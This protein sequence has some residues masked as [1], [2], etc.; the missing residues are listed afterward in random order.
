[1]SK[2]NQAHQIYNRS[3][4]IKGERSSSFFT[5]NL[6]TEFKGRSRLQWITQDT[7]QILSCKEIKIPTNKGPVMDNTSCEK[8][9]IQN[10]I[11]IFIELK[12]LLKSTNNPLSGSLMECL[13]ILL[14]DYKNEID[15]MLVVDK[16]LQKELVYDI[17]QKYE[18]MK[19]RSTAAKVV[20]KDV[21]GNSVIAT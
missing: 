17:L 14:K 1:M 18:S 5:S 21:N 19:A 6:K 10:T 16:Q 13:R 12:H 7:F 11:P 8:R 20:G 2:L 15:Q 9:I 4:H 3:I